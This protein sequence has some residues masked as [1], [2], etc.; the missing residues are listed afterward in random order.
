ML[1]LLWTLLP[2]S[3]ALP[4]GDFKLEMLPCVIYDCYIPNASLCH[5]RLLYS[6]CFL[7]SYT[8]VIFQTS[9]SREENI[10]KKILLAQ[11]KV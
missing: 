1:K 9:V 11:N 6:K 4:S 2:T 8:I 7:V 3:F 10:K 5:I